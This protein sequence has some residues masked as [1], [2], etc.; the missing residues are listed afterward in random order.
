MRG[1]RLF[2]PRRAT[3]RPIA[4]IAVGLA[5][6]LVPVTFADVEVLTATADNTIF[7]NG[8]SNGAGD[9]IFSGRVGNFG[10]QVVQRGL[11]RFVLRYDPR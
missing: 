11:L 5:A 7:D 1:P 8:N 2:L 3:R 9:S 4:W 6:V 10:G